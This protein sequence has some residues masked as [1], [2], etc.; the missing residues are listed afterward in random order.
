MRSRAHYEGVDV[1][2]ITA[3]AAALLLVLV[4]A[5]CGDNGATGG[6]SSEQSKPTSQ[7]AS[8]TPAAE[9]LT[10]EDEQFLS[11][12][13]GEL[14]PDSGIADATDADLIAAGHDGCEQVEAGVP[15]EEIRLVE[16]E[17][18]SSTGYYMDSSAIFFGAQQVYCPETIQQLD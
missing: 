7:E 18:P 5:G 9:D 3:A 6:T 8:E 1:P 13:R 15:L 2:K 11:I 12:V 16:G 10:A 4:L 14:L 17:E